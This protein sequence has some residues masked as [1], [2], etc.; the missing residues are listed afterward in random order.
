MNFW[1][2]DRCCINF[3][4]VSPKQEFVD[5]N[6][7]R[8]RLCRFICL[9]VVLATQEALSWIENTGFDSC[10]KTWDKTMDSSD[11]ACI[12]KDEGFVFL[13]LFLL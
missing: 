7:A 9:T 11:N 1:M 5:K 10:I 12:L 13:L 2:H 8:F 3:F 6:H 4:G